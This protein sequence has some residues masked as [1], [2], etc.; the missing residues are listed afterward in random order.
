MGWIPGANPPAGE[1][2][3]TAIFFVWRSG[4]FP[5]EPLGEEESVGQ[6]KGEILRENELYT[7]NLMEFSLFCVCFNWHSWTFQALEEK[8]RCEKIEVDN[9]KSKAA[10][11]LASGQQNPAATHA[12]QVL[13][14]F[15]NI[16]DKIKVKWAGC[17]IFFHFSSSCQ[18]FHNIPTQCAVCSTPTLFCTKLSCAGSTEREGAPVSWTQE[19]QRGARRPFNLAEQGPGKASCSQTA[20]PQREIGHRR[21]RST[22]ASTFEQ[23]GSRRTAAGTSPKYRQGRCCVFVW[24]RPTADQ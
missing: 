1:N 19:I 12:Q 23:A 13:Q 24:T 20:A 21:L 5:D 4:Q 8:V 14:R 7:V 15:D 22:A 2:C 9:L 6:N 11:M 18:L 3:R 10:E 17:F 16:S